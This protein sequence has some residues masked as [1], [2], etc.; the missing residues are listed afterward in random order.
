MIK[1]CRC[2]VVLASAAI[3]LFSTVSIAPAEHPGPFYVGVFG[4]YVAP[5][6]LKLQGRTDIKLDKSMALGVKGGYIVPQAKWLAPELEY[7]YLAK[8]DVNQPGSSGDFRAHNVMANL[9]CRYP[10]GQIHPFAGFGVGLSR[11]TFKL[12]ARE[13]DY[14]ALAAQL[15]AG[16]NVEIA[17]NISADLTYKWFTSTYKFVGTDADARNHIFQVGLNYHF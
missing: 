8:Q 6:D 1:I 4:S 7:T 11:G 9:L 5:A 2:T 17:P 14:S 16:V 10:E 15:I 12:E 13:D 3:L